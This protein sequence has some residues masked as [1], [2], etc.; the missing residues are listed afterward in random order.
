M[1]RRRSA[2]LL[3]RE[4]RED[5]DLMTSSPFSLPPSVSAS[6]GGGVVVVGSFVSPDMFVVLWCFCGVVCG[7]LEIFMR[8]GLSWLSRDGCVMYDSKYDRGW[9]CL[10]FFVFFF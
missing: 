4:A 9:W 10:F 6:F 7:V 2:R 1:R 3:R 5:V 8:E